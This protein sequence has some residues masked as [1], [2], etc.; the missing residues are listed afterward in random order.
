METKLIDIQIL[1]EMTMITPKT[2]R[3]IMK[4]DASFP[5]PISLGP[6]LTR[7]NYNDVVGWIEGKGKD[8]V[9]DS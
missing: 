3:K 1:S 7:W 9:D 2:L 6:R 4:K 8:V 5:R